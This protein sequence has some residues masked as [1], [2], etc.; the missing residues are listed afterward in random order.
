MRMFGLVRNERQKGN[1]RGTEA[2]RRLPTVLTDQCFAIE[3]GDC[4]C[5][6]PQLRVG[7]SK[8]PDCAVEMF[9]MCR[10]L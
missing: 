10:P 7:M 5:N 3:D 9:V 6:C 8:C 2:R 4:P 1:R